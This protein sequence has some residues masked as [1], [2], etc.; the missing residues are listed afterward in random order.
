MDSINI[1]STSIVPEGFKLPQGTTSMRVRVTRVDEGYFDVT[2]IRIVRGRAIRDTDTAATPRI[3]IAN[4]TFVR[5]YWPGQDPIGRRLRLAS[6]ATI[7]VVGVAADAKYRGLGEPPTEFLYYPVAQDPVPQL[8]LLVHTMGDPAAFATR[9]RQIVRGIDP[10]MIVSEVRT[11]EDFYEAT[12]VVSATVL[13]EIVGGMGMMGLA[14]ALAGLYGLVAH[15]VSRRTRE[16]GIRMSVGASPSSVRRMVLRQGLRLAMAGIVVGIVGSLAAGNA[17]RAVFA[18]PTV[19]RV[20]LSTYVIVVPL[21][22][23]IAACAAYVP[24]RRASRIDPLAAL[25]QE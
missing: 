25:R 12:T 18:F 21:L 19:P 15:S 13:V 1:D 14:L 5:H 23:V 24:A 2:G 9:I 11:M 10:D 16:I 4:E 17:L 6:G 20:D 8:T 7:E 22:I 3:A